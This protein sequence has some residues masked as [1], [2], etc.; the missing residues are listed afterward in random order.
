ME[1]RDSPTRLTWNWKL[2]A[3]KE[4]EMCVKRDNQQWVADRVVRCECSCDLEEVPMVLLDPATA[5]TCHAN[6]KSFSSNAFAAKSCSIITAM[7]LL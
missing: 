5:I 1:A 3:G 7:G 2:R 6:I 4:L